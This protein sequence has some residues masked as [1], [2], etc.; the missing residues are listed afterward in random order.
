[1]LVTE[2]YPAAARVRGAERALAELAAHDGLRDG[3]AR[4]PLAVPLRLAARAAHR[5]AD[6]R[7]HPPHVRVAIC[8]AR[9]VTFDATIDSRRSCTDEDKNKNLS[10]TLKI[11]KHKDEIKCANGLLIIGMR[12]KGIIKEIVKC[13]A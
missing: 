1:M 2:R 11:S 8:G 13:T 6:Y 12:K 9:P 7:V 3:G 10:I 5:L 4:L